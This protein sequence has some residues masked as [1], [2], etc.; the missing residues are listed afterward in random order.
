MTL[1][2][3]TQEEWDEGDWVDVT[4]YEDH[5]AGRR[6]Y[7]PAEAHPSSEPL[8]KTPDGFSYVAVYPLYEDPVLL[9]RMTNEA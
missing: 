2:Q 6:V 1:R 9:P 5:A 3:I 8:P 4:T 7:L